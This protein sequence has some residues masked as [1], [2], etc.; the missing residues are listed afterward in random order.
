MRD[1]LLVAMP[2]A[3]GALERSKI[4]SQ[5]RPRIGA[6]SSHRTGLH[7]RLFL[8]ALPPHVPYP[9]LAMPGGTLGRA[10]LPGAR[11]SGTQNFLLTAGPGPCWSFELDTYL[12]ITHDRLRKKTKQSTLE[13]LNLHFMLWSSARTGEQNAQTNISMWTWQWRAGASPPL[14]KE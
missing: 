3:H 13:S 4:W 10:R 11:S 6:I 1:I 14:E 5:H 12:A 9:S 7:S 8:L 2:R